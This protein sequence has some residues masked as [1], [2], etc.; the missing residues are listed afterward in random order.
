MNQPL[1]YTSKSFPD[2]AFIPGK[3]P[4]PRS[5]PEGHSY[6]SEEE[7]VEFMN[8]YDWK[9]SQSYLY[10]I[11]LFN[12][13]Y[14]WEAHEAWESVWKANGKE[15]TTADF[16][17]ALIKLT[18]AS[19]KILQQQPSG[20]RDHSLSAKKIFSNIREISKKN[21][22]AG[23]SL[24]EL[25]SFSQYLFDNA[26]ILKANQSKNPEILFDKFL[27]TEKNIL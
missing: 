7:I 16:I 23:L 22:Y 27:I 6:N 14:Y 13:G 9:D 17:K 2:Y 1:R 25:I 4:H 18:A 26:E 24:D 12:N 11:D 10:G 3:Y 15:G 8:E 20:I 5:H 21:I 19:V